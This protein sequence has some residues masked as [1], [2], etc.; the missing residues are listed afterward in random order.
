MSFATL[1]T[2]DDI[3]RCAK[4]NSNGPTKTSRAM[5]EHGDITSPS[6]ANE[7]GYVIT[8]TFLL[9]L[10]LSET[11]IGTGGFNMVASSLSENNNLTS[12]KMKNCG[13][14]DEGATALSCALTR[15]RHSTLIALYLDENLV[16]DTGGQQFGQLLE[17]NATLTTLSMTNNKIGNDGASAL[18]YALGINYTLTS[19]SLCRNEV[20][21]LGVDSLAR[22]V[23]SINKSTRM[24]VDVLDS[25][26]SLGVASMEVKVPAAEM[27]GGHQVF[28]INVTIFSDQWSI[29]KRYSQ[30][31]KLY[32]AILAHSPQDVKNVPFPPKSLAPSFFFQ[33]GAEELEGRRAGL[34]GFL[35]HLCA[36]ARLNKLSDETV[37]AMEH[38]LEVD[39]HRGAEGRGMDVD[40]VTKLK[41]V[42]EQVQSISAPD[43][44]GGGV[45]DLVLQN[46]CL[47]CSATLGVLAEALKKNTVLRSL[48]LSANQLGIQGAAVMADAVRT[49]STL[50][51]L[52][53]SKNLLGP[54]G[55]TILADGLKTICRANLDGVGGAASASGH[56]TDDS[57]GNSREVRRL[58][59]ST[60]RSGIHT[61][62]L[63][64]N[65]LGP[66][67]VGMLAEALASNGVLTKVNLSSNN[68]K[69][70]GAA[71]IANALTTNSSL[72][73]LDLSDN[74]LGSEGVVVLFAA[75]GSGCGENHTLSTLSLAR[76][77][78]CDEVWRA[79]AGNA[80]VKGGRGPG[81]SAEA[82]T[83]T[84]DGG[85]QFD[86]VARSLAMNGTLTS[87]DLSTNQIGD[88]G[89]KLIAAALGSGG[90]GGSGRPLGVI[91]VLKLGGNCIGAAGV[92][93][94]VEA[95]KTNTTLICLDLH[96]NE[97]GEPL[98]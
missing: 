55:M 41:H 66:S 97:I 18:A 73:S 63:Q 32:Q 10:D 3:K 93:A 68:A 74:S 53:L 51:R 85:N 79:A 46:G 6:A 30:F 96:G 11:A 19:L 72:K 20:G 48:N 64:A 92:T 7:S 47:G 50:S 35:S 38:F 89:G 65:A 61:L 70:M 43:G 31:E 15:N 91:R 88:E 98:S 57:A 33:I 21:E 49:N 76:N 24:E 36:A 75:F 87:I 82:G 90:S 80:G 69:P 94:M 4:N 95:L 16:S 54:E 83:S 22:V 58:M 27:L 17:Q 52:D 28:V 34:H 9:H 12:L 40:M 14:T 56:S 67:G 8:P 13:V 26:A 5:R 59:L 39:G 78:L 71:S 25:M 1:V 37:K 77:G 62:D 81:D 42:A 44:S 60:S 84:R 45:R 29:R 2:N 23:K 86:V